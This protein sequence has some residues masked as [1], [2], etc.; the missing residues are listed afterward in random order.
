MVMAMP[1]ALDGSG[2]GSGP[3]NTNT[4]GAFDQNYFG[5]DLKYNNKKK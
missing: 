2:A 1:D 3:H 5:Q 4:G